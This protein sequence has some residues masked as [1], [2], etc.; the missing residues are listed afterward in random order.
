MRA[1]IDFPALGTGLLIAAGISAGLL[2]AHRD[3]NNKRGWAMGAGLVILLSVV[4][5]LDLARESPR[6][7]NVSTPVIAVGVA[8][9]ASLGMV[10]A[11]HR[12]RM[13]YR[14]PLVFVTAFVLLLGGLLFAATYAA[15]VLP[16]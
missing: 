12:M 6:E 7:T 1:V 14:A 11:T 8:T 10:R 3:G 13:R 5:A 2:L 9:L 15:K 4:A 16:F